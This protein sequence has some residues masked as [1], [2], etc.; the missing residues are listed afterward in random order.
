MA[1]LLFAPDGKGGSLFKT[2]L[3]PAAILIGLIFIVVGAVMVFF[4][5]RG[6]GYKL[7]SGDVGVGYK[8]LFYGGLGM[9]VSAVVVLLFGILW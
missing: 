3:K 1:T 6:S 7:T 8:L 9:M 4:G 2:L 5:F